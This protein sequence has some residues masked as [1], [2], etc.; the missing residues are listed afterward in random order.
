MA[1]AAVALVGVGALT[2]D[3][4]SVGTPLAVP[5]AAAA[6]FRHLAQAV[7]RT[8]PRTTPAKGAEA[9]SEFVALSGVGEMGVESVRQTVRFRYSVD[10]Q[11]EVQNSAPHGEVESLGATGDFGDA[12][13]SFPTQADLDLY[14][15]QPSL[16]PQ[17]LAQSA[18]GDPET[19]DLIGGPGSVPP[20]E[21]TTLPHTAS[22]LLAILRADYLK[23]QPNWNHG[24]VSDRPP[25]SE[26]QALWG[27]LKSI[28]ERST[29]P[30]VMA[31]AYQALASVS[32]ID[33]HG[34]ATDARVR[35][36]VAIIFTGT[37]GETDSVIVDQRTG[38]ILQRTLTATTA[39]D[40]WPAGTVLTQE[41]WLWRSVTFSSHPP[42]TVGP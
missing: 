13:V 1:V 2:P 28:L 21:L 4:S 38:Q 39:Q 32:H 36:G 17:L 7:K 18:G 31:A 37:P 42:L 11:I 35:S 27:A 34:P 40:G 20:S 14:R 33:V 10:A 6:E 23:P 15:S 5:M 8:M 16:T 9:V 3:S 12:A 25:Y 30:A 22:A 29:D 26:T 41:V 19:N 24:H